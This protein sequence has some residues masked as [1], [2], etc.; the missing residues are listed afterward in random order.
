MLKR[1]ARSQG[2]ELV[3]RIHHKGGR[4]FGQHLNLELSKNVINEGGYDLFIL[5]DQSFG[6]ALY[7]D[8]PVTFNDNCKK[9]TENIRAKSPSAKIILENTWAFACVLDNPPAK[10][11]AAYCGFK[12]FAGMDA[13]LTQGCK[14]LKD[15]CPEIAEISPIGPG[16][17]NYRALY[18]SFYPS[19]S[20]SSV[21]SLYAKDDDSRGNHHPNINGSYLK[22]CVNYLTIYKT[23]FSGDVDNCGVNA[24]V[25]AK[26][27]QIAE[28]TVFGK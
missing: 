10:Y 21:Y 23:K 5:Q 6:P 16:F 13:K 15:K 25:A 27:R 8:D 22:A 24:T 20:T 3:M 26:I 17:A 11:Q 4:N 2:H 28:E 1:I 19:T 14:M 18:P 7:A 12:N 9:I